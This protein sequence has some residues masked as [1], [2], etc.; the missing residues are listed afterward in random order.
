[1]HLSFHTLIKLLRWQ[2]LDYHVLS[3]WLSAAAS[4]EFK[5]LMKAYNEFGL[6]SEFWYISYER[7]CGVCV[8][9]I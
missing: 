8:S 3:A 9:Q 6:F 7:Q 4:Y 5:Q 2:D 1:M